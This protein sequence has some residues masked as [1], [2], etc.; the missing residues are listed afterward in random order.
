MS[1]DV[2]KLDKNSESEQ[3]EKQED[4]EGFDFDSE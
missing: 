3:M 2:E 1:D 4:N